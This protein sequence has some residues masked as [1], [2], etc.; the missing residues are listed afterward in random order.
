MVFLNGSVENPKHGTIWQ[1]SSRSVVIRNGC[2]F[3]ILINPYNAT[4]FLQQM[5][6]E[7]DGRSLDRGSTHEEIATD[8]GCLL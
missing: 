3:K 1:Q 7:W 4:F 2:K 5:A 8:V 6:K